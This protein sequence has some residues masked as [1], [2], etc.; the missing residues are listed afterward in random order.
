MKKQLCLPL[1][2]RLEAVLVQKRP[3]K[4][5]HSIVV[6]PQL[7]HWEKPFQTR[8]RKGHGYH[9]LLT[10]MLER[11]WARVSNFD[12][13]D[14]NGGD[15]GVV[16]WV[17]V[18]LSVIQGGKVPWSLQTK[19]EKSRKNEIL[20][21]Q[22]QFHWSRFRFSLYLRIQRGKYLSFNV[23]FL[24]IKLMFYKNT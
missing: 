7:A 21:S 3:A 10:V 6:V 15:I 19:E 4:T 14:S 18:C 13:S 8:T 9:H 1:S 12:I 5:R 23:L 22:N 16:L 2:L 24:I 11:K 17:K 20:G